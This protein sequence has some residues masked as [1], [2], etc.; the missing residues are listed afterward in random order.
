MLFTPDKN[1]LIPYTL[2][3]L[4]LLV[5]IRAE[6]MAAF[7]ERLF[8]GLL[9]F[10]LSSLALY[11]SVA[12]SPAVAQVGFFGHVWRLGL[13]AGVCALVSLAT[14]LVAAP[15]ARRAGAPAQA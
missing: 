4:G 14:A 6:R 7:S 3:V 15:P 1:R 13:L 12:L 8:T 10:V 5:A 2:V 11:A 9:A